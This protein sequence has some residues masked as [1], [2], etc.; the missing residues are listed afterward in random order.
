MRITISGDERVDE[1]GYIDITRNK[2]WGNV[3][4]DIGKK[5]VLKEKWQGGDYGAY[6]WKLNGRDGNTI[7]DNYIFI[8]DTIVYSFS[9]PPFSMKNG[10]FSSSSR[11]NASTSL[12]G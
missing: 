1:G 5:I 12:S 7:D 9:P 10:Y 8:A 11:G 3:K 2:R 4:T 6:Q